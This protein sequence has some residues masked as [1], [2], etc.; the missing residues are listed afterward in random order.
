MKKFIQITILNVY[1]LV[2]SSGIH[3]T[4]WGRDLSERAYFIY[5][6]FF[7]SNRDHLRYVFRPGTTVLDV[8]ANIGFFTVMFSKWAIDGS[9]VIAIEPESSNVDALKRSIVRNKSQNVEIIQAAAAENEGNLFLSLNPTNPADHR[10]A[11]DG[12]PIAA[13]TI[14]GLM[15]SRGW[16]IVSL[17]KIDI[18][19]AEPRALAGASETISRFH[20]TI[21]MEVDDEALR[22]A[23]FSASELIDSL[24]CLGY[25]MYSSTEAGIG[26]LDK[27]DAQKKR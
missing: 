11:E 3:S 4:T 24:C 18:Q 21:F 27:D 16:P 17:I 1:K 14:D 12:V 5:K 15:R 25:R 26:P 7:E 8:G 6:K 20:P 2:R 10:L 22:A 19:G 13:V 23:G 9:R